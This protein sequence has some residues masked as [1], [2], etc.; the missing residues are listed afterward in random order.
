MKELYPSNYLFDAKNILGYQV[1]RMI[2]EKNSSISI[3][4]QNKKHFEKYIDIDK[5]YGVY[6]NTLDKKNFE[7]LY[8]I[9]QNKINMEL[10]ESRILISPKDENTNY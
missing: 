9:F 6:E 2:R 10:E 7:Q 5:G 3:V 8:K 1:Y 4:K